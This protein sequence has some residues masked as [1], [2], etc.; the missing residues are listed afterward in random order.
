MGAIF[1]MIYEGNE[2]AK[3]NTAGD[4]AVN[5]PFGLFGGSDGLPHRY[6]I[7]S[8]GEERVL[9]T[10]ETEVTV[11]PGDLIRCLSSGG[12]GYGDPIRRSA[13][14]R[15]YDIKNGLTNAPK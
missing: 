2:P 3:L 11:L 9:R 12:G 6:S 8:D 1:E 10:K 5:A 15:D 13:V 14:Q 7:I 4:G